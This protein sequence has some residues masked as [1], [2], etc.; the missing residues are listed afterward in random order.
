MDHFEFDAEI[1]K[2]EFWNSRTITTMH[3]S[4]ENTRVCEMLKKWPKSQLVSIS[5]N[6]QKY[7]SKAVHFK[8]NF[9]AKV[10]NA[11]P[12]NMY[13]PNEKNVPQPGILSWKPDY[14]FGTPSE[15]GTPY[16][17][18]IGRF[19]SDKVQQSYKNTLI[20]N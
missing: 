6:Q 9:I 7:L 14:L 8:P 20:S 1:L 5:K 4:L 18:F 17:A 15:P 12:E 13:T 10:H 2:N 3:M 11:Y 16:L 19:S